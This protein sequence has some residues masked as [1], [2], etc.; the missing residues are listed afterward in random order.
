MPIAYQYG[1]DYYID[2]VIC[3]NS[4][5]NVVEPRL[6]SAL[7][8]HGVQLARFESNQAGGRVAEKVQT[9]VKDMGGKTRITTKYTTANKETKIVVNSPFVLQ[10]C[11]FKD[12]SVIKN[13]KEYRRFMQFLCGYTMAGRNKYD[14]VPDAMA[15]L[16]EYI[17]SFALNKVEIVK[18]PF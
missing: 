2:A 18:R 15:M 13:D 11:L 4:N 14:D 7:V 10:R 8:E 16:A 9:M 3:D 5:P 17:T 6:A 12:N 1:P